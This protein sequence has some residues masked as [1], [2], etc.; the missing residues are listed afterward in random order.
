MI[1]YQVP[2]GYLA[3]VRSI[4]VSN[5]GSGIAKPQVLIEGLAYIFYNIALDQGLS[6]YWE[7]NHVVNAGQTIQAASYDQ[8]C[9]FL[10]SGFLLTLVPN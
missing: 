10:V 7:G 5:A 8:P 9:F 4:T 1:A 2:A 3:V 6:D